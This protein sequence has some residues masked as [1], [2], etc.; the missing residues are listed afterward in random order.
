MLGRN[1]SKYRLEQDVVF[2]FKK[3]PLFAISNFLLRAR[4]FI[5][6]QVCNKK[7]VQKK[8]FQCLN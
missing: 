1:A 7:N 3:V 8:Y 4:D 2:A 6:Y 5:A